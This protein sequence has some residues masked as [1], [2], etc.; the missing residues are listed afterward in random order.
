MDCWFILTSSPPIQTPT[1]CFGSQ[2]CFRLQTEGRN[3]TYQSVSEQPITVNVQSI[4]G[5]LYSFDRVHNVNILLHRLWTKP[6][7]SCRLEAVNWGTSRS[8]REQS[9]ISDLH[10]VPPGSRNKHRLCN[11]VLF[12]RSVRKTAKSDY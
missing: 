2:I 5:L 8:D 7:Y 3:D 1:E 9:C 11:T 4:A 6:D 10:T 12:F